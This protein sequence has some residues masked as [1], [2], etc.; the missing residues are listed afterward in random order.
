MSY[1]IELKIETAN[2]ASCRTIIR[3]MEHFDSK[4]GEIFRDQFSIECIVK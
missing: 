3:H 2:H 4:I 1:F